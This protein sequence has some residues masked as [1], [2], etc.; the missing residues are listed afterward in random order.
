MN[1]AIRAVARTT[2]PAAGVE[3]AHDGIVANDN[4]WNSGSL[5][6][7]LILDFKV[8]VKFNYVVIRSRSAGPPN[9]TIQDFHID[10]WDAAANGENGDWETVSPEN[11]NPGTIPRSNIAAS[12]YHGFS[13]DTI[14]DS[15]K[16]RL[17]VTR[18]RVSDSVANVMLFEILAYL[19][20]DRAD[21]AAVIA[22]AKELLADTAVSTNGNDVVV[23][24]KWVTQEQWNALDTALTANTPSFNAFD[25]TAED[26]NG[27]KG[28]IETA[29]SAFE[30]QQANGNKSVAPAADVTTVAKD[31]SNADEIV[32]TL[33]SDHADTPTS[34]WSIYGGAAGG[35]PLTGYTISYVNGTHE[36]TIERD[37]ALAAGT[38]Y[39]AVVNTGSDVESARLALT[40]AAADGETPLPVVTNNVHLDETGGVTSVVFT[41]TAA[42]TAPD[43]EVYTDSALGSQDTNLTA[44]ST[45]TTLTLT[46]SDGDIPYGSYW[47]TAQDNGY[48][49]ASAP[50][51]LIIVR[52]LKLVRASITDTERDKLVVEFVDNVTPADADK[53]IF[54]VKVN[55][56]PV[57]TYDGISNNDKPWLDNAA[58]T[59]RTITDVVQ[60]DNNKKLKLTM[61]APAQYAEIIRLATLDTGAV[62]TADAI[63]PKVPGLI[64]KNGVQRTKWDFESTAGFYRILSSEPANSSSYTKPLGDGE[65]TVQAAMNEIMNSLKFENG[66]TYV[67]SLAASTQDDN[68]T[69]RY[70]INPLYS[71]G[72]G[73]STLIITAATAG[74]K[75]I[76]SKGSGVWFLGT[77]VS[78]VTV[79]LDENIKINDTTTSA[80]YFLH[81]NKGRIILDGGKIYTY[82]SARWT[83]NAPGG[84]IIMNAGEIKN[85]S[86]TSTSTVTVGANSVFV[87]HDGSINNNTATNGVA[88]MKAGGVGIGSGYTANSTINVTF[89]GSTGFYMTGGEISGN[90]AALN[91][92]SGAGGVLMAGAFQKT[93]GVIEN[94]NITGS[95]NNSAANILVLTS[96]AVGNN[97]PDAGS[98]F[99][100]TAASDAND[101]LFIDCVKPATGTAGTLLIPSWGA[102][103]WDPPNP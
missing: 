100:K 35:F 57:T 93:G 23:T 58:M 24:R 74:E 33:T 38:Y 9:S 96:A 10:A 49:S 48:T 36:L 3:K 32:F 69:S 47:L 19:V 82:T 20:P 81:N 88:N 80:Q 14:Q 91:G 5:T 11:R 90:S 99:K 18:G 31:D 29:I 61:N 26:L 60:G 50:V 64:V 54:Q 102:S 55:D 22:S 73:R 84:Y 46:K 71:E 4:Y 40:I 101:T 16:L 86:S 89:H 75:V 51:K 97:N 63:L 37:T 41:L 67:I 15:S 34:A 39:V 43:W 12:S 66:Y 53:A 17:T 59:T 85:T 28:D 56:M 25:S 65:K 72:Q 87:M 2:Y 30:G 6:P 62:S 79:I 42:Y 21:F 76:N 70:W 92:G 13:F 95:V 45:G 27:D 44:E 1:A 52:P 94:N 83:V 8:P 103:S 98:N 77:N 7:E 78:G 68:K